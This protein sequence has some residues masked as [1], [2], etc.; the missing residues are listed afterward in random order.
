[1][2]LL[3]LSSFL[4]TTSLPNLL[5]PVSQPSLAPA[6]PYTALGSQFWWRGPSDGGRRHRAKLGRLLHARWACP[7][8]ISVIL[9]PAQRPGVLSLL[10]PRE[11]TFQAHSAGSRSGPVLSGMA[12]R[13]T[14][15]HSRC[16]RRA[17]TA[18]SEVRGPH[19]CISVTSPLRSHA[20]P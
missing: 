1:M 18:G 12:L 2:T 17:Q 20:A 6:S 9:T 5:S 16:T 11:A 4:A 7:V 8:T 14:P 13:P 19:A 10:G 15:L 3:L